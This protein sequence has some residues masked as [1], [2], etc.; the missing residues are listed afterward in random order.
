MKVRAADTPLNAD[1]MEVQLRPPGN[2]RDDQGD[3]FLMD[4]AL[5]R[6]QADGAFPCP[7]GEQGAIKP[8]QRRDVSH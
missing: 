6:G 3:R 1:D 5:F 4:R 2:E 8:R 7:T